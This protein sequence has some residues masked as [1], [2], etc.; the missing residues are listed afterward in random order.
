MASIDGSDGENSGGDRWKMRNEGVNNGAFVGKMQGS[1]N[2]VVGQYLPSKSPTSIQNSTEIRIGQIHFNGQIHFTIVTS[3]ALADD[4]ESYVT[5]IE[6]IDRR[7]VSVKED[8]HDTTMILEQIKA[9]FDEFQAD[10][11]VLFDR[12]RVPLQVLALHNEI[13]EC[14]RMFQNAGEEMFNVV[15]EVRGRSPSTTG[16]GKDEDKGQVKL[17]RHRLSALK[18]AVKSIA[19]RIMRRKET[20]H[21]LFHVAWKTMDKQ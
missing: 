1:Y 12:R 14:Q 5:G 3:S 9:L 21:F 11:K 19:K 4:M 2:K 18:E 15:Q 13:A 7:I 16:K 6:I 8:I 10:G 17:S 20:L